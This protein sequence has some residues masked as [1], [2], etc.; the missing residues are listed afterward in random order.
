MK[1]RFSLIT[2]CSFV[3]SNIINNFGMEKYKD[4]KIQSN[5]AY[6]NYSN[7]NKTTNNNEININNCSNNIVTYYNYPNN[8]ETTNN[9]EININKCNL[10]NYININNNFYNY[11]NNSNEDI[12]FINSYPF[13]FPQNIQPKKKSRFVLMSRGFYTMLIHI[14]YGYIES[15]RFYSNN[16][17]NED[18]DNMV[19]TDLVDHDKLNKL[20]LFHLKIGIN[21][22][23]LRSLFR[24]NGPE[25]II[26]NKNNISKFTTPVS[27]KYHQYNTKKIVL[28]NILDNYKNGKFIGGKK[29][30][31]VENDFYNIFVII[32]YN[33]NYLYKSKYKEKELNDKISELINEYKSKNYDLLKNLYNYIN[34]ET[35]EK[36]N[37]KEY[38]FCYIMKLQNNLSLKI[39]L[40]SVK[41]KELENKNI[42]IVYFK[43]EKIFRKKG[44]ATTLLKE[45]LK[46]YKDYC[47]VTLLTDNDG[48]SLLRKLGFK[49]LT[50]IKDTY[51]N[52][53]HYI[54][55]YCEKLHISRYSYD[56]KTEKKVE[57]QNINN[58]YFLRK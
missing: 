5:V 20:D 29:I 51:L 37:I 10:N 15:L 27:A 47:F 53:N 55:Y 49:R 43:T 16:F 39:K 7:N 11:N 54:D 41:F 35:T 6:Y 24:V 3:T 17:S 23:N 25:I 8:N 30:I 57:N 26:L 12:N 31:D 19:Y 48:Y 28:N 14:E 13:I 44:L 56:I 38:S 40:S 34:Y 18:F 2:K 22:K 58:I 21:L 42:Q 9:N 32:S 45:I 33:L 46:A 50:E 36:G 1:S 4:L 52:K